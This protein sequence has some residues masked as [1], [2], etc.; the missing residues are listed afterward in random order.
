[1]PACQMNCVKVTRQS[2]VGMTVT[3]NTIGNSRLGFPDTFAGSLLYFQTTLANILL[4]K[5]LKITILKQIKSTIYLLILLFN[6]ILLTLN[7]TAVTFE[8]RDGQL[9]THTS[10]NQSLLT[11]SYVQP[12][13]MIC[14]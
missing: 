3:I 12:N 2:A 11:G 13:H 5:T 1:M 8:P 9:A 4:L 7:V 10:T 14:L 6:Q